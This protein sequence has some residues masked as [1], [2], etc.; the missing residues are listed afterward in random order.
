MSGIRISANV[1]IVGIAPLEMIAKLS[2][3]ERNKAAAQSV[4]YLVQRHLTDYNRS[5]PNA[6]GGK[7]TNHYRKLALSTN[8]QA[9][10]SDATVAISDF[11]AAMTILGG[12]IRPGKNASFKSGKPTA[13]LTVPAHSESYGERAQKFDGKSQLIWFKQA[14]GDCVGM[15]VDRIA[16]KLG[17]GKIRKEGQ[18]IGGKLS[19]KGVFKF[20]RVLYW[21]LSRAT[22]K[23]RP[24]SI[25]NEKAIVDGAVDGIR[26]L[27]QSVFRNS[28]KAVATVY[29]R[30]N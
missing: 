13:A 23:G 24:D 9:N 19:E 1:Q 15:I 20:K 25:P 22:I 2:P 11:R 4:T 26:A 14:K 6:L 12:E 5:H 27:V 17:A 21:L 30:A 16:Q 3:V 28:N 10:D 18:I 7:R 8:W 29:G